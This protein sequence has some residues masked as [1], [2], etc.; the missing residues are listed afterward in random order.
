M[1]IFNSFKE[2][3]E[4]LTRQEGNLALSEVQLS[5]ENA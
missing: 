5:K 4:K 1:F 2:T 3:N